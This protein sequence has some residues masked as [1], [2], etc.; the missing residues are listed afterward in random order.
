[1]LNLNLTCA[2]LLVKFLFT[3]FANR[4][5]GKPDPW[6]FNATFRIEEEVIYCYCSYDQ[7]LHYNW[8]GTTPSTYQ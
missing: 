6:N 3:P 5:I 1:M 8:T 4:K 2:F 7:L